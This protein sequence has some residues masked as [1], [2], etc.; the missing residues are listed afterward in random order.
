MKSHANLYESLCSYDNLELAFK[1]ARKGKTLKTYVIDFEKKLKQNLS[2]LRT[3]LLLHAYTPKPLET[4]IL[5]D[6]KTRKISKS[7]FADRL[8]HHALI[9]IIEPIFDKTFIFDS[10]ANRKGKGT[11]KALK[12]FDEFKRKASKNNAI[13]C[14]V[15]KADI[16]HYFDEVSHEILIKIIKNKINDKKIIWLIK[17][18]LNNFSTKK[19]GVG[20]PLGNLTSQFFAN[21]YLNEL[22]KF[23]KHNLKAKYYI[24]YVDDFVI[25]ENR[26]SKL[27]AYKEEID[28]FLKQ[29]LKLRLH[30]DKTNI[31][32]I[33]QG[34]PFLGFRIFPCHKLLNERNI[35]KFKRKLDEA[36]I[37]FED[38]RINY[39][40][41]HSIFEGW[42][43]YTKT[44]NAYRLRKRFISN[45][46]QKF[47]GQIA[48]VEI[49]RWMKK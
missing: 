40:K 46:E 2:R 36:K 31:F 34:T 12:R 8:V 14:H 48:N 5:R 45:F 41:I 19:E 44:A 33:R 25:I 29:Q 6:P 11:L 4:F 24:R 47:F 27:N 10:Y 35:R 3:E 20:M 42:L 16:R 28:K 32:W 30:P 49:G 17:K 43:A 1:K 18:I 22:D 15:L 26:K 38:D 9:N 21:I 7:D 37:L 39:D 13:N 23:V